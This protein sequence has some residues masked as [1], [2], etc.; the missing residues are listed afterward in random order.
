MANQLFQEINIAN[1]SQFASHRFLNL[2][3]QYLKSYSIE[4]TL[5]VTLWVPSVDVWTHFKKTLNLYLRG[6]QGDHGGIQYIID[7]LMGNS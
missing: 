4:M 3:L 2:N 7:V 1:V 5:C 6:M